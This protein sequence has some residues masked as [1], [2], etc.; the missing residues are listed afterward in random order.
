MGDILGVGLGA[1]GSSKTRDV[2][3]LGHCLH[4]HGRVKQKARTIEESDLGVL[5]KNYSD[6]K[7]NIEEI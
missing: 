2:G 6:L 4:L 1:A 7:S 5:G 3:V